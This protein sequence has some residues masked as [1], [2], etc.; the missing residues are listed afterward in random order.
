MAL[1]YKILVWEKK[2]VPF[3]DMD[4]GTTFIYALVIALIGLLVIMQKATWDQ[5]HGLLLMLIGQFI[6]KKWEQSKKKRSS[7]G[8]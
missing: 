2:E 7:N 1:V 4:G 8:E 5:V 3:L 6:G